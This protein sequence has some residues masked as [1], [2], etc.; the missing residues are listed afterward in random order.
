M[1]QKLQDRDQESLR[2]QTDPQSTVSHQRFPPNNDRLL[3][4]AFEVREPNGRKYTRLSA[5]FV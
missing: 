3:R 5:V 1:P 4:A 2:L